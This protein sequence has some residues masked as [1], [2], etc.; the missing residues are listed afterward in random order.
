M[1]TNAELTEQVREIMATS[2]GLDES[3]LPDDVTQATC[4]AWSSLQH[5]ALMV[6]IEER[7]GVQLAMNDMAEMTSMARIVGTVQRYLAPATV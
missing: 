4:G 1:A 2:L 5:L 6:S 7:F 3:D